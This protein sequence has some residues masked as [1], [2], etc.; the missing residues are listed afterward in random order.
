MYQEIKTLADEAV[1]QDKAHME[2][3][4]LAISAGADC[5]E[6]IKELADA[7]VKR[8]NRILMESTLRDIGDI[9]YRELLKTAFDDV[10]AGVM[11]D[12]N[13][14]MVLGRSSELAEHEAS[15]YSGLGFGPITQAAMADGEALLAAERKAAKKTAKGAK[16]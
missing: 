3:A 6:Q 14:G 1:K 8:Q 2:A 15:R 10:R 11:T 13:V 5:P 12:A 16:K 7:A 4:L 9:A